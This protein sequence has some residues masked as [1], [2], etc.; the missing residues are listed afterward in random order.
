M[1]V[2]T[3]MTG[4][5]LASYEKSGGDRIYCYPFSFFLIAFS[6]FPRAWISPDFIIVLLTHDCHLN[7]IPLPIRSQYCQGS[8]TFFSS[9][10]GDC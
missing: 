10:D 5:F 1:S 7:N 8:E 3:S 9:L 4:S 2:A 6:C